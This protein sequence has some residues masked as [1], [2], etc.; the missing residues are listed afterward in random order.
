[1]LN[2]PILAIWCTEVDPLSAHTSEASPA[3]HSIYGADSVNGDHHM[4][5]YS[6]CY[7][8]KWHPIPYIVHY[9]YQN[10]MRPWSKVVH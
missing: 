10:L 8:P 1:M 7:V 6:L 5:L 3:R 9:F 2:Q 4:T